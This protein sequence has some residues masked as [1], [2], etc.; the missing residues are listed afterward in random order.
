MILFKNVAI[1]FE[2]LKS[3]KY[4]LVIECSST[5]SNKSHV[6]VFICH[7]LPFRIGKSK[8]LRKILKLDISRDGNSINLSVSGKF[9]SESS[10]S[11]K[12]LWI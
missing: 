2:R 12:D 6:D 8:H 9:Y 4:Y 11:E 7:M 1:R 5:V 10:R 3:R